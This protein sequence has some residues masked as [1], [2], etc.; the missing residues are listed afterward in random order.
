VKPIVVDLFCGAGGE[1][2][3]IHWAAE[4]AGQSIELFAINHWETAIATHSLNFPHDESIC[5][6]IEDINP[7]RVVPS[8]H[9]ELLWASPACTHFSTAR[10]GKPMDEQSRVTPFTV[11]NW[12]EKLDVK[13]IIIENV[14]EFQSWG[15]LDANFRPIKEARGA[16]FHAFIAMIRS[17]GYDVD[18][19]VLNCADYGAPTTRRRLFVQAVK[20]GCGKSLLWPQATHVQ[21]QSDNLFDSDKLLWVPAKDI[22]DWSIPTVP[23]EQRMRPLAPNTMKRIRQGIE[24]YWG[25]YA[26]PFI[27]RYNGGENRN[28]SIDEPMPVLDTSNRYGL[29][30]PLLMEY[31]GNGVCKPVSE[32]VGV[33]TT[34]D[35]FAMIEPKKLSIGFRM[36][37]PHEL[38]AAQ[39][40]PKNYQ[41]TGTRADVVKQIGNAVPPKMAEALAKITDSNRCSKE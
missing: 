14:P 36:L 37:Q 33:V 12:I 24:K 25:V 3:G 4:K 17:F 32:P 23:L 40:F 29:V 16:T 38:A 21:S 6:D 7:L 31:Y 8:R 1:S 30:E 41:F 10:G 20:K 11:C 18:W 13:R 28:H 39:S 34:K 19:R 27:T 35:R 9:V 5:R 22:I 26:E 15:P 2:Q